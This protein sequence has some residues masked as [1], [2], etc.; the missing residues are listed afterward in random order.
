VNYNQTVAVVARKLRQRTRRE[1]R[2]VLDVLLE[3]WREELLR[4][5]GYIRIDALGKLYVEQQ[6][7]RV[8]G[9]VR[10]ALAEQQRP[11][12]PLLT[13]YYFR[14]HPS[15]SLREALLIAHEHGSEEGR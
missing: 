11:V 4:P 5:D 6:T 14:F 3:V 7:M 15:E 9:A 13:R 2:E 1:V 12:P 8:P 10:R